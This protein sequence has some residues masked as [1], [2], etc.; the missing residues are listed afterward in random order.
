MS[1][2]DYTYTSESLFKRI[3]TG[4][5][6]AFRL[7]YD[8]YWGRIYAIAMHYFHAPL[9]S[10]DIVQEVFLKLWVKRTELSDVTNPDAYL[11]RITRNMVIDQMRKKILTVSTV[12]TDMGTRESVVSVPDIESKEIATYI[13][14]AIDR[15]SPQQREVYLLAKEEGLSLREVA[16][17]LSISYN[18]S[19]EYMSL[20]LRS[21]RSFLQENLGHFYVL[22]LLFALG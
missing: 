16:E 14:M 2:G 6:E 10:Q 12:D 3:A 5:E 9:P 7:V 4:D 1:I 22:A 17:R 18:T 8:R 13:R 15:L 20:A 21:I 19:R 11:N